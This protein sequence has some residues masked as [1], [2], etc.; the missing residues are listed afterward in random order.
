VGEAGALSPRACRDWVAGHYS[1][2]AMLD[3]YERVFAA[4]VAR[5]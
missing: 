4:A 3:G 1:S 5:V 2:E